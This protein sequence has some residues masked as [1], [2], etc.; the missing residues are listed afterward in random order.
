[1]RALRWFLASAVL[2]SVLAVPTAALANGGAFI[3]FRKPPGQGGGSHFLGGGPAIGQATVYVPPGKEFLFEQGPFYAFLLPSTVELSEGRPIPAAAIRLGTFAILDMAKTR[4]DLSV[5][6]TVPNVDGG[7]Y[8]IALCNDPCTVSGFRESLRGEISIV[9]TAR[10]ARLLT[11]QSRLRGK[12]SQLTRGLRK[13]DREQGQLQT[14]LDLGDQDA[15]EAAAAAEAR[16]AELLRRLAAARDEA[17]EGGPLA[18]WVIAAVSALVAVVAS[19]ALIRRRR[20]GST[21]LVPDT[22]EELERDVRAER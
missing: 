12:A 7:F 21:L 15:A 6:F 22:I 16:E 3:E 18:P 14:L 13:A 20:Q 17:R 5:S 19:L 1:M 10:E 11:A 8:A 4:F 9:A 2:G